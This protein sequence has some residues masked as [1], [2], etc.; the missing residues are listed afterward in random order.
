MWAHERDKNIIITRIMCQALCKGKLIGNSKYW[1]R[2]A[3]CLLSKALELKREW[4]V[5]V[6]D[7]VAPKE[8]VITETECI[9]PTDF[10]SR[11][12]YCCVL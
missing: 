8:G 6:G 1:S 5:Y 11:Q 2:E 9:S 12:N 3:N 4:S 7:L 10:S